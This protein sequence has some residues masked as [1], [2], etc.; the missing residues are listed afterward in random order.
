MPLNASGP[1]S[2]GGSTA[3]QSV[4][5]ELGF[6]ATAQ[7]SFNDAQVRAL[8]ATSAGTAL[9]MPTNFYGRSLLPAWTTPSGSLGS[10]YTQ[11]ANSYTVSATNSPTYSVVVGSL[12]SGLTLNS[13]S[14]VISGT[15]AAGASPNYTTQTYN[16]TVRA[17]NGGGSVDRAF[18]ILIRSRF[19]GFQCVTGDEGTVLSMTAPATKVFNRVDFCSY[20]TPDGSCGAF[21]IGGC[22]SG[23]S[24]GYNPT[25]TASFSVS[26]DNGTWGDPCGGTFKRMY[27]QMSWGPF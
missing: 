24:N 3:G 16:F 2:L 18:S 25:P 14:G 1:I 21:T 15:A 26:A 19:E 22:N 23:S 7:I 11:Q 8:T 17:T 20:G 13:G 6:S 12:P 27:I 5:L 4:N 9:I 10:Q